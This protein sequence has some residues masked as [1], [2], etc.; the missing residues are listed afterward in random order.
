MAQAIQKAE[1]K[2]LGQ[3]LELRATHLAR[4]LP[5]HLTPERVI[6]VAAIAWNKTPKLRECDMESIFMAVMQA[7]ELGLEPGGALGHA[8]LVPYGST[9]QLIPG[10]RGL[11][12]LAR[13]SGEIESIEAH[14][15]YE[16]DKFTLRFGLDPKLEHEPFLDGDPGK[17]R[18]TYAVAKLKGGAYQF[19]VMTLAQV[20]RIRERS[21][22]GKNGPWVT[23]FEEMARKTVIRR[24]CKYLPLSAE[25]SETLAKALEIDDQDYIDVSTEPTPAQAE[26]KKQSRTD[27]IKAKIAAQ[28]PSNEAPQVEVPAEAP[29]E[30]PA[31]KVHIIDVE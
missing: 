19:E 26:E 22:A 28:L 8:Y 2:T 24:L 23:D 7:A 31:R 13:R 1:A 12:E 17:V 21:R 15:V 11:I 14:I 29:K 16:R 25:K 3:F 9:C 18:F 10:Y 5:R 27:A 6:K 20:E 30:E 4:V